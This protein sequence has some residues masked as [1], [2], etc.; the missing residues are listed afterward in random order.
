MTM[1][2]TLKGVAGVGPQ[3]ILQLLRVLGVVGAVETLVWAS[4]PSSTTKSGEPISA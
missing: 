2:K 1:S 4:Q 3:R